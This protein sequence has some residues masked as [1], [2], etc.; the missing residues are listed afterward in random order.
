MEHNYVKHMTNDMDA[1][2]PST[3]EIEPGER[4]LVILKVNA[5]FMYICVQENIRERWN[6][7]I[8]SYILL[9]L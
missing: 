7:L 5:F 9:S 4:R 6:I 2:M 8:N 3:H 1:F